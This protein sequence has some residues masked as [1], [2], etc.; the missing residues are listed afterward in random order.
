[1]NSRPL[2][3]KEIFSWDPPGV[4]VCARKCAK[5]VYSIEI[6]KLIFVLILYCHNGNETR[7]DTNPE[8]GGRL[9]NHKEKF[10]EIL[11]GNQAC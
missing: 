10:L 9:S 8:L 5:H 11:L 3:C 4:R 2:F 7:R 1:M 6:P